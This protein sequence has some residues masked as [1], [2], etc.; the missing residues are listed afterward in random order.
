MIIGLLVRVLNKIWTSKFAFIEVNRNPQCLIC[1]MWLQKSRNIK[2]YFHRKHLDFSEK[3]PDDDNRRRAIENLLD[4]TQNQQRS[5]SSL[6][7]LRQV[8]LKQ[9]FHYHLK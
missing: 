5:L 1:H 3:Y 2:R 8:L 6:A 7:K 4:K 9:V